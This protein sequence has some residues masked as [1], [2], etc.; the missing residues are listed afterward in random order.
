M[1]PLCKFQFGGDMDEIV[2]L[3]VPTHVRDALIPVARAN[4]RNWSQQAREIL[5]R[6]A[7]QLSIEQAARNSA[8]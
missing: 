5:E 6:T 8:R 7:M 2:M 4:N 3:R 1:C